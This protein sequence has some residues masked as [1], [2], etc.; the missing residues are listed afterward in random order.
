MTPFLEMCIVAC[1]INKVRKKRFAER[2]E[3]LSV[4]FRVVDKV[5]EMIF[6]N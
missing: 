1:L 5:I 3:I 4:E 6:V 2:P